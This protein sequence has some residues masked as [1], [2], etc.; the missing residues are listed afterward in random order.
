MTHHLE[1]LFEELRS[2]KRELDRPILDLTF[3]CLDELRDY[4]RD[5]RSKGQSAVDLSELA[6]QVIDV[7]PRDHAER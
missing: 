5:L 7:F 3:R 4:H 1:S 6:A 2:K